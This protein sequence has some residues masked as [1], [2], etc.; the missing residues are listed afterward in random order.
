MPYVIRPMRLE[1]VEE[2]GAI[3]RQC[4]TT[5]WPSSAYRRE[6]RDNRLGRYVVLVWVD[7]GSGGVDASAQSNDSNDG[8]K[9]DLL[10]AVSNLLRP[11]GLGNPPP[12]PENREVVRGFAG[13]W[14]MLDEAHITTIC[15]CS[16]AR[17]NGLGELLLSYL[18]DLARE[19][20]AQRV[21][22]E[23]RISNAVAQSLYR[24]YGFVAEGVRKR[25]YSDDNEDALVMWS[26]RLDSP[27]YLRRLDSLKASIHRR[28][29]V[30]TVV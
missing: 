20:G 5:P 30:V 13:L 18:M 25:Y 1:D 24:K 14:L 2:V 6:I 4:F 9:P 8:S 22:L 29:Q 10:K 27:E 11:L 7:D 12:R 28:V 15:V 26:D 19:L 3:E 23:V 17:G 21:T 16:K